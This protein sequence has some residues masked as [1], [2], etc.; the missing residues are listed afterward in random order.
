MTLT[1]EMV[2]MVHYTP[3]QFVL[4]AASVDYQA[5]KT[6]KV[7]HEMLTQ[8]AVTERQMEDIRAQYQ[9]AVGVEDIKRLLT[10]WEDEQRRMAGNADYATGIEMCTNE[11]RALI[12]RAGEENVRSRE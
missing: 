7:L 10:S 6:M 2:D 12:E 11:L 1:P 4:M 8:A 3:E 5:R 9:R